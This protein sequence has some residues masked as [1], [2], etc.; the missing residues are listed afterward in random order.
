G[1]GIVQILK[2]GF[3]EWKRVWATLLFQLIKSPHLPALN[4]P[5]SRLN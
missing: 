3:H 2:H 4:Q 1:R 5:T